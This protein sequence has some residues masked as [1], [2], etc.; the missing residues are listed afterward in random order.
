MKDYSTL[1]RDQG[2][3]CLVILPTREL[4]LQSLEVITSVTKFLP[5]IVTTS[6]TGGEK[7]KSEKARLRKGATI[8]VSTPGRLLDHIKTTKAFLLSPL[9]FIVFDEA[10]RLLDL[11]FVEVVH[12]LL[13]ILRGNDPSFNLPS[14]RSPTFPQAI[15][16]IMVSATINEELLNLTGRVT[17]DQKYT[18]IDGDEE[19]VRSSED[20]TPESIISEMFRPPEQLKQHHMYVSCKWRLSALCAFLKSK[21]DQKVLVF[22]SSRNS[23]NLHYS[24]LQRAV[25]PEMLDLSDH[26]PHNFPLNPAPEQHQQQSSTLSSDPFNKSKEDI[27]EE[28]E[29]DEDE[30]GDEKISSNIHSFFGTPIWRLHGGLENDERSSTFNSIRSSSSGILLCTDVAARGVHIPEVDWIVQYDPP[31]QVF[32]FSFL[33]QIIFIVH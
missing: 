22:F 3:Y 24:L 30:E 18:L 33:I 19:A 11:G 6:L 23:V 5:R 17:N 32:H 10:E 2:T 14:Y 12:E 1:T 25:W 8:I 27:D 21:S 29:D 7:K 15:Q 4:C 16:M 28:E 13:D 31:Q 9:R 26:I 20:F